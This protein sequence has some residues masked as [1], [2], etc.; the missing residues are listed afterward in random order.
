MTKPLK[1]IRPQAAPKGLDPALFVSAEIVT[2]PVAMADGSVR[3]FSFRELSA[4][5][6]GR[7][8]D[9]Y[10]DE[11]GARRELAVPY[12]IATALCDESG[13]PVLAIEDAARLKIGVMDRFAGV[14]LDLCGFA[15]TGKKKPDPR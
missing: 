3:D 8:R 11:D 2:R 15:G 7:Y 13:A 5:E 14:I 12:L 6:F 10:N 4:R 9:Y 1:S